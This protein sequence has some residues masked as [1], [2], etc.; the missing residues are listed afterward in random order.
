MTQWAFAGPV[1]VKDL[2]PE[3]TVYDKNAYLPIGDRS[4]DSFSTIYF[5]LDPRNFGGHHLHVQCPEEWQFFVDGKL[6][7]S[8]EQSALLNMDS[9]ALEFGGPLLIGIHAADGFRDGLTEIVFTGDAAQH[10]FPE[11]LPRPPTYFRDYGIIAS[12]ILVMFLLL[13]YRTNPQLT[14]DYFSFEKI[15]S[16]AER[17]EMQLASR[18]T[19][20]ANLLFY[21]FCALL[22]GF[23]LSAIF[24]SAGPFFHAARPLQITSFGSAFWV[25][26]KL[27]LFIFILLASKL[28]IV[29]VFSTL[30]NFR[31]T[32]SFQFF[33]FLRFVLFTG[34]TMAVLS[35]MF[36]M[37]R[38]DAAVFYERLVVLGLILLSLGSIVVLAKLLGKSRFSFFHLFSYL[39]ISEFIPLVIIFKIFF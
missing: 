39:C 24:Y 20:S 11:M 33:N 7:F 29:L 34:V 4:P 18:I 22:A 12:A 10:Y 14:L 16:A 26:T 8:S 23:L 28:F 21:L 36:F 5:T 9:L 6:I 32:I 37:F 3:W 15:F 13:L 1:L 2:R 19:S 38:V 30:F 25:W 31:E 35:L 17:N 27:S